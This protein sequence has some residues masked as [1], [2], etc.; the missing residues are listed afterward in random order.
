MATLTPAHLV[1]A[2]DEVEGGGVLEE[3]DD[4]GRPGE[5]VP[6]RLLRDLRQPDVLLVGEQHEGAAADCKNNVKSGTSF[7][8]CLLHKTFLV[9]FIV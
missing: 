8:N 2:E 5:G 6:R 4:D 9:Q 7:I 1:I 3:L